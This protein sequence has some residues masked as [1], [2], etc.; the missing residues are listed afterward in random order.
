M[1][2]VWHFSNVTTKFKKSYNFTADYQQEGFSAG[3]FRR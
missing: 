2:N 1:M 3:F